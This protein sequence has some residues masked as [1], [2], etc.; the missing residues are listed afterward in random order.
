MIQMIFRHVTGARAPEI[1]VVPLG[2]HRELILG[3][4][5]SAAVRFDSR[6]DSQVGRHHARVT[7]NV[8]DGTGFLLTDL[9]S[10]NGTFV[11]A[12]RVEGTVVLTKND[13]I[14]LGEGGPSV[15]ISWETVP[16]QILEA[17]GDGERLDEEMGGR[18]VQ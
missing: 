9:G 5:S 11:N 15:E 12:K 4:A 7:W 2:E 14:Q 17:F 1:D 6:R 8:R 13:M 10:R 16:R 3:R 18:F